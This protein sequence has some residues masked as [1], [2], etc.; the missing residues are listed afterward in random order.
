MN[1]FRNRKVR[2]I[3]V[4]ILAALLLIAM[5]ITMLPSNALPF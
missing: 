4:G 1:M 3:V 2:R 5:V